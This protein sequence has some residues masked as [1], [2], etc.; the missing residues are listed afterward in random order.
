MKKNNKATRDITASTIL[1]PL[2]PYSDPVN[3][4]IFKI[5]WTLAF[6]FCIRGHI[7]KG[8]KNRKYT[9][10]YIF[11]HFITLFMLTEIVAYQS[12]EGFQ[13]EQWLHKH[14]N[15]PELGTKMYVIKL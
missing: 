1:F 14:I 3:E 4:L 6:I 5:S 15:I 10:A 8:G 13:E 9:K 11:I 2:F 12:H 7:K